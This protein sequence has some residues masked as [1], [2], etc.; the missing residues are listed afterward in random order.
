[1][2]DNYIRGSNILTATFA[3]EDFETWIADLAHAPVISHESERLGRAARDAQLLLA[4]RETRR[5]QEEQMRRLQ[6]SRNLAIQLVRSPLIRHLS[7]AQN[8]NLVVQE[9]PSE[10]SRLPDDSVISLS[11][12]D[13][14]LHQSHLSD[15]AVT[16]M[17]G[18]AAGQKR[19][20]SCDD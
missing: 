6:E 13:D 18:M 11:D 17:R 10:P 15:K 3:I 20:R 16:D 4:L 7:A 12:G 19:R 2:S 8:V 14:E 5:E 1:M 9:H